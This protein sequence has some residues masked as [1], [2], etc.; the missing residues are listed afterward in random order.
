MAAC[1]E[2]ANV[3]MRI[4]FILKPLLARILNEVGFVIWITMFVFVVDKEKE[5]CQNTKHD[6]THEYTTSIEHAMNL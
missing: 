4:E 3:P 2:I 5:Y 6:E 1:F